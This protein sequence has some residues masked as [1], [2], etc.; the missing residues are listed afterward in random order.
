M[1][2]EKGK[3]R[4][5]PKLRFPEFK[6]SDGW[7]VKRLGDTCRR[8]TNGKANAEDHEE[9]GIYPLF[10]RSEVIKASN[11]FMFDAEAV[12]LPGEGMRFQPKYF[13]GKFNLHQRAYALMDFEGDGR[14]VYHS[15]DYLKNL[16]ATKAVRSTVLS[17]RLPIVENFIVLT[18]S[19]PEQQKIANCL[20]SIDEVI[21]AQARKIEALKAHKIGLMQQLFPAEGET[22]PRLRFPEFQGGADWILAKLGEVSTIKSGGTP[23]RTNSEYWGGSIPWVTTSLIDSNTILDVDEHITKLGLEGSSAKIFPKGT[24]LMAMYG[25]GKTRGKV[26]VLGI[27]AATNQACAAILMKKKI[28]A[29]FVFQN[30][31]SRYEEIR[32]ISNAG[33]QENLSSGLIECIPIAYPECQKEQKRISS[34]L[35]SLDDIITA[36]TK[37]L[38]ALSLQK[39]GLMQGLFPLIAE[40]D[41]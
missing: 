28:E 39:Q 36:Q 8:I 31:A 10:D 12:V 23:S 5:V 19:N 32:R 25:Q 7:K 22:V 16:L 41:T 9:N 33:G 26:A 37:K 24:I 35:S 3:K 6:D 2:D 30:L 20:S 21:S 1:S 18:P 11:E 13:K 40:T 38:E 17:L 14:F 15:M 29:S 34:C 4:L 27:D